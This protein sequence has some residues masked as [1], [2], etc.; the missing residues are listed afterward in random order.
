MLHAASEKSEKK[1]KKKKARG[2]FF[3]AVGINPKKVNFCMV[4]ENR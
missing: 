4:G 3:W 2:G 1:K